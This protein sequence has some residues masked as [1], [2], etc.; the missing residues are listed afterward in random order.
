MG[1]YLPRVLGS[2]PRAFEDE[3]E[4]GFIR[5]TWKAISDPVGDWELAQ[6][7][8]RKVYP[9]HG[10]VN[11]VFFG[12]AGELLDNALAPIPNPDIL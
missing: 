1:T 8:H 12:N 4:I 9:D 3:E 2:L 7:A 10:E 5:Q 6:K 11:S